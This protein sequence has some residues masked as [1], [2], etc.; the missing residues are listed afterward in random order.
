MKRKQTRLN[1]LVPS[2]KFE[3]RSTTRKRTECYNCIQQSASW[4]ADSRSASGETSHCF[5]KS[6]WSL[7]CLKKPLTGTFPEPH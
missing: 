6:D 3:I 1:T 2:L 4:E 7:S 5:L